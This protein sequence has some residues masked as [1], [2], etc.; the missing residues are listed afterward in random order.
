MI[1]AYVMRQADLQTNRTKA[2]SIAMGSYN[3][4][5]HNIQRI[6]TAEGFVRNEGDMQVGVKP[7]QIPYRIMLPKRNEARNLLVPVAFSASH[8]AYSSVRM[9]PQYMMIGQAAGDTA[10]LAIK[11]GM[12][13]GKVDI[14]A[15]Q[16]KLRSQHAIL[17]IEQEAKERAR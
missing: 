2:D 12:P 11:S 15:L 9:E 8:V 13:V 3:S 10:A 6:I 7:Y 14:A 1:G 5:S 4:D 16:E 17:H